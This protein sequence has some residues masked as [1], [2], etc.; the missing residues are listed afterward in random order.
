MRKNSY[1]LG[2]AAYNVPLDRMWQGVAKQ[3]PRAAGQD[4]LLQSDACMLREEASSVNPALGG[5]TPNPLFHPLGR[6]R[7][8]RPQSDQ[9][10][11]A[12][13]SCCLPPTRPA[14]VTRPPGWQKRTGTHGWPRMMDDDGMTLRK[15]VTFK[16]TTHY[17]EHR[18]HTPQYRNIQP[19]TRRGAKGMIKSYFN[20]SAGSTNVASFLHKTPREGMSRS[21]RLQCCAHDKS[22]ACQSLLFVI[23]QHSAPRRPSSERGRVFPDGKRGN[24]RSNGSS[25]NAIV[26]LS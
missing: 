3:P 1:D 26:T 25:S 5:K 22:H 24:P 11:E 19:H 7:R 2:L 20:S 13:H 16:S 18:M 14:E 4:G 9:S 17:H 21:M 23:H 15:Q 6:T 10:V 12:G 8:N